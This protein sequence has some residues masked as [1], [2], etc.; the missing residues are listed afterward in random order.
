MDFDLDAFYRERDNI[1]N[2]PD[3]DLNDYRKRMFTGSS[4]RSHFTQD[5]S[6]SFT[7]F[8]EKADPK[9]LF[10]DI[11]TTPDASPMNSREY[12]GPISTRTHSHLSAAR[13]QL[14]DPIME[15]SKSPR[16]FRFAG[17]PYKVWQI[18]S[19]IVVLD[20]GCGRTSRLQQYQGPKA[21]N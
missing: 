10:I 16:Y 2:Q 8:P 19:L 3:E 9:L 7:S 13:R 6:R 17:E 5:F 20:Y 21:P 15:R 14:S 11:T 12:A 1:M 4:T 18:D